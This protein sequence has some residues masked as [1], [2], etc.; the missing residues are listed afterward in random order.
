MTLLPT[1]GGVH[2]Q[3][4]DWAIISI[5]GPG[6]DT[7][8][9]PGEVGKDPGAFYLYLSLRG[10]SICAFPEYAVVDG[11]MMLAHMRSLA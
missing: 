5:E 10:L 11:Q 3:G 1:I 6:A 7:L 8:R 9:T 2:H 4:E